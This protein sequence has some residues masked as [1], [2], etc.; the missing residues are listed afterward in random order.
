MLKGVGAC[1]SDTTKHEQ[2][3]YRL[4]QAVE[5]VAG[6]HGGEAP[7]EEARLG[8]LHRGGGAVFGVG[9]LGPGGALHSG[10]WE[11]VR[12]HGVLG[13]IRGG[14]ESGREGGM[15]GAA[16][17]LSLTAWRVR[18]APETRTVHLAAAA[19]SRGV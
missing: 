14:L 3:S 16:Q 1:S 9:E 15:V 17:P 2:K 4:G 11:N 13:E 18:V 12:I 19:C 5:A 7:G 8:D 10:S 6:V